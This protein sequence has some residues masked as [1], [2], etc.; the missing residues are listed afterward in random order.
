MNSDLGFSINENAAVLFKKL[1]GYGVL[2]AAVA[3]SAFYVGYYYAK[4]RVRFDPRIREESKSEQLERILSKLKMNKESLAKVMNLMLIEMFKGLDPETHSKADIKMFPT[5]VRS[6]PNGT[7]RGD[8]LALDLG[9]TNFRVLLINLDSG[10]VKVTSKVFVIPQSI[11]TGTGIQL[12]DHIAHCLSNF[13]KAEHLI[14]YGKTYPLGF[15]FSFPC[16][17]KGLA[18]AT[19]SQWTK[20]FDC[21]GVVGE[22]VVKFLQNAIDKRGDIKV[23]VLA[24]VNDTVG[25]LLANAYADQNTRIGLIL[26][27]GSNACYIENLENVK[28]W[29]EDK[30]EP[31]QVLI[32]MEWGAFGNNGVLDFLRT[33]YDIEVDKTS[34][35]P[36]KQIYEKMIS[37]MYMGEIVRLVILD[38]WEKELLFVGHRDHNWS[39]D[40]RQA[41]YTKGSFYTKYVSEIETDSGVT[42][43]H[44][45][46]V[47][48]QMGLDKPTYD[49]CAIVQYVCKLVSRRAAQLS[50]CGLAV[51]LNHINKPTT[52]IAVDGS[53]YRFHPKF[54]RIMEKTMKILVNPN[55]K[56]ECVLSHDGSGIGAA[57]SALTAPSYAKYK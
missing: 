34:L 29:T 50:A 36:N 40:Y 53:L 31:N 11:M 52:T 43:R 23:D 18:S 17:Q 47:L 7:E 6:L 32:N 54:K 15:T 49:D 2:N 16:N 24:L 35:N 4:R 8:I 22:D 57:L 10:E 14:D 33:E 51:L 30:N 28:T 42:F 41:L 13:M 1:I 27:T 45:K 48:E 37:G 39:T 46:S 19:L 26:G 3:S 38:L 5:Y 44:T 55:I 20:G 25:T 12:F 9:G 56:Y 21:E